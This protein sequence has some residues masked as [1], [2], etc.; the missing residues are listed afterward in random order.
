MKEK[1]EKVGK[2][3]ILRSVS[4]VLAIANE[5]VAVIGKYSF[6]DALWY[7]ILSVALLAVTAI[8][9]AWENNDWTYLARMATG[10]L[11]AMEDG[12]IDAEEVKGLLEKADSKK[13]EAE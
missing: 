8:V 11:D 4:L 5:V 9:A 3:T 2:G 6:A 10:V 1:F 7:Q 13:T 12:K